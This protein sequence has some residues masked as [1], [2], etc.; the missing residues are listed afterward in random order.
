MPR[1]DEVGGMAAWS[2]GVIWIGEAAS[3]RIWEMNVATDRLRLVHGDDRGQKAGG[4]RA[5]RYRPEV[6]LMVLGRAGVRHFA[7]RRDG[8]SFVEMS[9]RSVVVGFD[10]LPQGDYI[11]STGRYPNDPLSAH[12]VHRYAATGEHM[13]S[14]HAAFPH[15][16][17]RAVLR[18][19][20]K[21]VAVTADGD[22]L[23]S[24]LAPFKVT[25]YRGGRSD[26]WEIVVEDSE[27]VDA[28]EFERALPAPRT[29]AFQW[30]R[31]VFVDEMANG[32]ILNVVLIYPPR[33]PVAQTMWVVVS[34]MGEVLGR[35]TY[36]HGLRVVGR[37]GPN[38]YYVVHGDEWL[39]E[40]EVYLERTGEGSG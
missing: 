37:A 28:N 7:S 38:R 32:D 9:N 18:L 31:T 36:G 27:I 11:V 16:D 26:D 6:G 39:A 14:W 22:V 34:P 8:G 23:V 30:N 3:D 21:P 29:F 2:D 10:L 4:T 24:E 33:E 1:A 17:W 15:D 12:S 19:S 20:G 13:A 35:S 5:M 40:V 25:R